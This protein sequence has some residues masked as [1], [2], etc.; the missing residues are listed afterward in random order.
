MGLPKTVQVKEL[1][2][3]DDCW[4][5]NLIYIDKRKTLLFVNDGTLFNFVVPGVSREQIRE[6]GELFTGYLSCVLSDEGFDETAKKNLLGNGKALSFTSVTN[7][8]VLGSLNDLAYNYKYSIMSSGGIH[9]A[10]VPA[11][12]RKL[13]RMPMGAIGYDFP[14]DKLR[15]SDAIAT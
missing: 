11:I 3:P 9:S 15:S 6:M 1:H 12:I 2:H 4:H 14:I 8:S 10:A 7:P 13:N 5:A